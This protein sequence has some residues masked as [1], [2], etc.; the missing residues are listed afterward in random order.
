MWLMVVSVPLLPAIVMVS[1]CYRVKVAALYH[2]ALTWAL[3]LVRGTVCV[4]STHAFVFSKCTHGKAD[5]VLETFDLYADTHPSLHISPHTAEAVDEVM[6][7]VQPSRV[8]ELG[9]HCGYTSVR[10]LRLLPP[11]GT[12]VTVEGDPLT[13]ELGEEIILVAGFKHSQF[14]VLTSSS[15][16][17][18]P[19]LC[20]VLEPDQ[21][22]SEGFSLVLMDHDPQRYLP[23]LLALQR[24]KL[25]SPS[26]C[27][28]LLIYRNQRA[29]GLREILDHIRARPDCYDIKSELQFMTE[30]FYQKEERRRTQNHFYC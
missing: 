15:A 12:L 5:S 22:T 25:L 3:R 23:D 7:R 24:E 2:R 28:V 4:R 26:G 6:R 19:T 21:G 20:P 11:A 10:L 29:E 1:S 17:A 14:Q 9:M 16:E 30:I 18:I 27:S 13:A 8:L